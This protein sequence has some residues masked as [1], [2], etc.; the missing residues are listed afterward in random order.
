M[1]EFYQIY[2]LFVNNN[3]K[4]KQFILLYHIIFFF[5]GKEYL[6]SFENCGII[7]IINYRLCS[8]SRG[9]NIAGEK[10]AFLQLAVTRRAAYG[11]T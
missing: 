11:V 1:R 9:D 6:Y 3:T 10:Q 4:I 2:H 8:L 7:K 5:V